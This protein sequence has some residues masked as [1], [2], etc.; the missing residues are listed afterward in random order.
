MRHLI[1]CICAGVTLNCPVHLLSLLFALTD[2]ALRRFST[3][4]PTPAVRS[5]SSSQSARCVI[6]ALLHP[7]SS[8]KVSHLQTVLFSNTQAPRRIFAMA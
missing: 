7:D 4:D 3:R 5:L 1:E 8:R 6:P 2:L